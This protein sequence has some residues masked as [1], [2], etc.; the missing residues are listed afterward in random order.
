MVS[1]T[2][3]SP[4]PLVGNKFPL[5]PF[6]RPPSVE[7][8]RSTESAPGWQYRCVMVMELC[9]AIR[10]SVNASQPASARRVSK[11]SDPEALKKLAWAL[12][13]R[14]FG[15]PACIKIAI[16]AHRKVSE[17]RPDDPDAFKR[18]AEPLIE[19]R[20]PGY[21]EEAIAAYRKALKLKPD[22]HV[23]LLKLGDLLENKGD[24]EEALACYR[25]S[26]EVNPRYLL[27]HARLGVALARYRKN[28]LDEAI[29]HIQKSNKHTDVAQ[30]FYEIGLALDP[31][32]MISPHYGFSFEPEPAE[33]FSRSS[34]ELRP[35]VQLDEAI[36]YYRKSLE[37][38]PDSPRVV[39]AL[40]NALEQ[41]GQHDEAIAVY[42][43]LLE[44][45]PENASLHHKNLGKLHK[46]KGDHEAAAREF[47]EAERLNP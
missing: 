17:L 2:V 21:E 32:P 23:A 16:A 1:I 18:L 9:P 22:D 47:A 29:A 15:H 33:P 42:Q 45:D 3:L 26:A 13:Y 12:R 39:F 31:K 46:R 10:A 38:K 43:K 34:I 44:L 35:K 8:A 41:K 4:A 36:T 25:K 37:L 28:Q 5:C 7:N 14:T 11:L 19:V 20:P 40:A 27:P 30:A 24:V 6:L